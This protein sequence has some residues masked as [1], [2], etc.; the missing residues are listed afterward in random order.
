MFKKGKNQEEKNE[1]KDEKKN[2]DKKLADLQKKIKILEKNVAD[3]LA[4]WQR[5][6]AD[7]INLKKQVGE[8]QKLFVEFANTE[9]LLNILPIADNFERA[10]MHLPKDLENNPWVE[11]VRK[12]YQE[13]Q[14]LLQNLGC[15]EIKAKGEKF[16]PEIHEAV[17]QVENV[18]EKNVVMEVLEKGYKLHGK[19]LRPAKVKVAK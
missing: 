16:N 4:G 3:Y 7:Y 2:V 6:K 9:T 13:L 15:E 10:L 17:A 19:L 5:A 12:I 11:G 8:E 1:N 14:K 18:K